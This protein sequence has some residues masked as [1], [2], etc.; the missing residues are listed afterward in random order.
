[1]TNN[2]PKH[3]DVA[4]DIEAITALVDVSG[5]H[6]AD[7]GCAAGDLARALV[8]RGAHVVAI[9]PDPKQAALNA[10]AEPVPGLSFV[11]AP[12]Q[13][14]P[15]TSAS[16]DG[17]IFSRS[18]HHVP[19]SAMDAALLEAERVLKPET[20]FMFVLEPEVVGAYYELMKP[21]HDETKV[22]SLA[23]AALVRVADRDFSSCETYMYETLTAYEGFEEF[24]DRVAARTYL[25]IA[26]SAID[27]PAIRRT[28][29]AGLDGDSYR[30]AAP[31]WIGLYRG[32]AAR[33]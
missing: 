7:I 6:L 30:F 29:E 20:G 32:V 19:D 12:A 1:M 4:S 26:E 2:T 27:T 25:N 10:A 8:A 9:E 16:M 31:H 23:R 22:R 3:L 24:R 5:L 14:M 21:F 28:F 17:V 15:L 33:S 13:S 11:E 18:L